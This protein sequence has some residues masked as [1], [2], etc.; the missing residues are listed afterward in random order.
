MEEA[1]ASSFPR[2]FVRSPGK[3][4][5]ILTA[6]WLLAAACVYSNVGIDFGYWLLLNGGLLLLGGFWF[7]R[8]VVAIFWFAMKPQDRKGLIGRPFRWVALPA[9]VVLTLALAVTHVDLWVRFQVSKPALNEFVNSVPADFAGWE[10]GRSQ[11]IGLF[12]VTEAERHGEV[13]RFIT[14]AT[15]LDDAGLAYSPNGNPPRIGEDTYH[16]LEGSWWLWYRS[17]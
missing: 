10:Y 17:W 12:R 1:K 2:R 6:V 4:E 8:M 13:V 9:T 16:Q 3:V 11:W 7:L 5:L 14:T 15:W